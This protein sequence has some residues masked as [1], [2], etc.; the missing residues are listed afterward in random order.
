VVI[1]HLTDRSRFQETLKMIDDRHD[2][3]FVWSVETQDLHNLAPL[4]S[5]ESNGLQT[6]SADAF[7]LCSSDLRAVNP[8]FDLLQ[9]WIV[10]GNFFD[11]NVCCHEVIKD[12][13]VLAITE[14]APRLS[15]LRKGMIGQ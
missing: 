2:I 11:F 4:V 6:R 10:G 9:H 8:T 14:F 3:S 12:G 7:I 1:V 13:D 15:Y 5:V